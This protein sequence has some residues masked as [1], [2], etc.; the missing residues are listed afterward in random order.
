MLM[1]TVLAGS[2]VQE[3]VLRAR[4]LAMLAERRLSLLVAEAGVTAGSNCRRQVVVSDR[5]V[6]VSAA[7]AN[8]IFLTSNF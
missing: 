1:V 2:A 3:S 5:K 7:S 8:F 6:A 4:M